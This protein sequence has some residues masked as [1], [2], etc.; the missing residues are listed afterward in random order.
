MIHEKLQQKARQTKMAQRKFIV[1]L[2][3]KKMYSFKIDKSSFFRIK[4]KE[5]LGKI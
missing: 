1:H 5:T 2:K 3:N 4:R